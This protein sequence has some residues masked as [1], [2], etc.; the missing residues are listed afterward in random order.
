MIIYEESGVDE[1]CKKE[2]VGTLAE[3]VIFINVIRRRGCLK[4]TVNKQ[5]QSRSYGKRALKLPV[6][7]TISNPSVSNV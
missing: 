7:G 2:D 3:R 1:K 5:N 6:R 4:F